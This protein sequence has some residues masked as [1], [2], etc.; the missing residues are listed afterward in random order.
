M[1]SEPAAQLD[2][3]ITRETTRSAA[4]V[5]ATGLQGHPDGLVG[6]HSRRRLLEQRIRCASKCE[7]LKG[8]LTWGNVLNFESYVMVYRPFRRKEQCSRFREVILPGRTVFA[9][10][11]LVTES[12]D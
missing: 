1:P 4:H 2:L 10:D 8:A 12:S 11:V 3:P 9:I 5:A 7:L 6:H